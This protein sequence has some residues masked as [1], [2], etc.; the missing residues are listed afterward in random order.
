MT[1]ARMVLAVLSVATMVVACGGR[2]TPVASSAGTSV[3]ARL[4][5]ADVATLPTTVELYGSV[6]AGR[7][8]AVSSRVMAAVTAVSVKAGDTVRAGQV[9][10]QIDPQTALGQEAQARGALA[11]AQAALSVAT[12]NHARF[13]ALAERGAASELEPEVRLLKLNAD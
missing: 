7:S 2:H 12:R 8:V 9:L 5:R 1:R 3:Q 10:V 11:Q 4:G 13:K 6:E